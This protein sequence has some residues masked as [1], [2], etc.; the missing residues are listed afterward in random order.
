MGQYADNFNS[1][2]RHMQCLP[3]RVNANGLG[4]AWT[5]NE[6]YQDIPLAGRFAVR[7]AHGVEG[8][9]WVI[10]L[11]SVELLEPSGLQL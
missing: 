1:F 10:L 8:W 2:A 5:L 3:H 9:F 6:W 11:S 7:C 4:R